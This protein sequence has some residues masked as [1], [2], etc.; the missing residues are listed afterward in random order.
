MPPHRRGNK[1]T[2]PSNW[3]DDN[4]RHPEGGRP[5][6]RTPEGH[7]EAAA[8]LARALAA[9]AQDP[10]FPAAEAADAAIR[11]AR[12]HAR[13]VGRQAEAC[14]DLRRDAARRGLFWR[15]V[16]ELA[17]DVH[18]LAGLARIAEHVCGEEE[19]EAAA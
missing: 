13:A 16:P 12:R 2:R 7:E 4:P 9:D 15:T 5:L 3:R 1:E 6:S 8:A 11:A 19:G 10:A 18:D 14:E 17:R